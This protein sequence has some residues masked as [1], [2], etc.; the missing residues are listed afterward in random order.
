LPA[1][2]ETFKLK[3]PFVGDTSKISLQVAQAMPWF[4]MP[5]LERSLFAMNGHKTTIPELNKLGMVGSMHVE[6]TNTNLYIL[7]NKEEYFFVI[8]ERMTLLEM[9]IFTRHTIL[10]T[11]HTYWWNSY[12]KE[13]RLEQI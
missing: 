9:E 3:L 4:G 6:L 11:V 7:T 2:F 5:D 13:K 1:V 8:D 12:H 10:L